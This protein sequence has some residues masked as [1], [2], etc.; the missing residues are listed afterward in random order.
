MATKKNVVIGWI[1]PKLDEG[2]KPSRWK[3][4]RPTVSLFEHADLRFDRAEL[5]YQE[6]FADLM[7]IISH[8]VKSV[9]PKTRIN[10]HKVELADP[11]SFPEI[12]Q[13]LY[14][15]AKQYAFDPEGENY[16]LH[17]TTGTHVS[18]I[19]MFLLAE[20]HVYP[21]NLLQTS[22][23]NRVAKG[24]S[25]TYEMLNL[26]GTDFDRIRSRVEM[27]ER[28]VKEASFLKDG[29][30]T[31]NKKFNEL[32]DRIQK[33]AINSSEPVLLLGP[34]GAGK[35]KL[36]R[37][38]YEVKRDRDQVDGEFVEV[39]C[40]TIR[41]DAAMSALFGHTKG[42]FTGADKQRAGYLRAANRGVLFL[43]EIAELALPEQAMLLRAI[44]EKRFLP[45]GS[46]EPKESNFQLIAGTN[47]DLRELVRRGLFREDLLARLEH[48]SYT[49]PGL[50]D[51]LEDIEPNIDFELSKISARRKE[52][53]EF[54]L[55]GRRR[56]LAFATSAEALW[57]RNFR[58]LNRAVDRMTT[59][60]ARG[61]ITVAIVE[62]EIDVLKQMWSG[63][64]QQMNR[65]LVNEVLS[66]NRR[67]MFDE[68]D[69]VQLEFVIGVCRS[70]PS[71]AE[72]GRRLYAKS[73]TR[74][75]SKNDSDR[76]SKLLKRFG[77]TWSD[78]RGTS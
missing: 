54:T 27:A 46:D 38:I 59:L 34:T 37:K 31:R 50:R 42:A 53:I 40:S 8:D 25:G 20:A 52:K 57:Q 10:V 16:Y 13:S 68:I 71:L 66:L 45:L 61:R 44:E 56:F 73:I 26:G 41:G 30:N 11:W 67:E 2:D 35:T 33:I 65:S 28:S 51:R 17:L 70:C 22:P 63:G 12:Y 58:D 64:S 19:C 4:W 18:K 48:W 39:N 3:K 7:Q 23:I 55:E 1:G 43:D 78:V 14:D 6:H 74:K 15:F 60:A 9:S 32:I 5:F 24:K 77:L 75:N 76:V 29:I 69:L 49:L 21:A 72:A 36:A 47:A 62:E